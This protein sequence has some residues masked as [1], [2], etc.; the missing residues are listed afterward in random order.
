[1]IIAQMYR[2]GKTWDS[3]N[4]CFSDKTRLMKCV[5]S[6]SI[7]ILDARK[8]MYNLE[9]DAFDYIKRL[10]KVHKFDAFRIHKVSSL[11]DI[12]DEHTALTKYIKIDYENSLYLRRK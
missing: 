3:K 11:L 9:I 7:V 12:L 5:G 1:M 6:D 4:Q 2:N 10:K 8:S